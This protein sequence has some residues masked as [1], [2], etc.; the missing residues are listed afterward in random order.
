VEARAFSRRGQDV[1]TRFAKLTRAIGGALGPVVTDSVILEGEAV[2]VAQEVLSF[3]TLARRGRKQTRDDE[4]DVKLFAFD[5]LHLDN[6]STLH[7]PLA[8]RRELLR[9]LLRRVRRDGN[10]GVGNSEAAGSVS[11]NA[12]DS[13]LALVPSV[14]LDVHGEGAEEALLAAID[15]AVAAGA[16][17]VVLKPLQG[18]FSLYR[19]GLRSVAWTKLKPAEYRGSSDSRDDENAEN[20]ENT[21]NTPNTPNTPKTPSSPKATGRLAGLADTLDL[22]PVA[23]YRGKGKRAGAFGSFL[24]AC[25]ADGDDKWVP[26]CRIGTGVSDEFLQKATDTLLATPTEDKNDDAAVPSHLRVAAKALRPWPDVWLQPQVVW[27]VRGAELTLS[28]TYAA[29]AH[30]LDDSEGRGLALRFP[31]LVRPRADKDLADATA[32]AYIAHLFHAQRT[33]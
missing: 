7:L 32:E 28:P 30:L 31:R 8:D 10:E 24:L 14:D 23:A 29:A 27:E 26:V 22:V 11:S 19:A 6:R 5:L 18:P 12:I 17:G 1:T 13:F 33:A 16:E 3:Q 9:A 2:A 15:R 4:C 20:A 21:Q 25:R